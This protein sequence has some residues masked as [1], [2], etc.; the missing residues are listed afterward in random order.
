VIDKIYQGWFE[1]VQQSSSFHFSTDFPYIFSICVDINYTEHDGQFHSHTN[2][3][4]KPTWL[5]LTGTFGSLPSLSPFI[6][7]K[8]PLYQ[9]WKV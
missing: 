7:P 3:Q 4:I 9:I 6:V 8:W 2:K 1:F 5:L